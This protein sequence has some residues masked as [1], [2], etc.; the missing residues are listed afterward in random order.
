MTRPDGVPKAAD[1]ISATL[2]RFALLFPILFAIT[3]EH[4]VAKVNIPDVWPDAESVRGVQPEDVTFPTISPFVPADLRNGS[5]IEKTTGQAQLFLP[6]NAPHDHSVPAVVL[7]HGA[8]GLVRERGGLY[9]YQLAS[10]GVAVMVVDTFGARRDKG[11]GFTERL[12][13]ITETMMLADAYAAL[14]YLAARPEIDPHKVVLT[15]FSYG[16]MTAMYALYEQMAQ[17]FSPNGLRFAGHVSFYGPCITRFENSRTTGAPLLM[18]Y[19]D[20]DELIDKR[21]CAQIADDLRRGGSAVT[22]IGYPGAVHQWDGSMTR[23]LIGR[24][25]SSCSFT[26]EPNSVIRDDDTGMVMSGPFMRKLILLFCVSSR[27]Y[28]IGRDDAVRAKSNHDFGRFLR[29]VFADSSP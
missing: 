7:L 17:L 19:G 23:R 21:R 22:V 6:P 10:M 18:L 24:N 2:R 3:A 25:L 16:G 9:G 11:V 5:E 8:A 1:M 12:L 15:G 28:P 20:D 26:V 4:A 27:P 29:Q 14:H 13:N